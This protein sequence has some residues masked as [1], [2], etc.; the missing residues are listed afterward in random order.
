MMSAPAFSI[1]D[2]LTE[3]AVRF[4]EQFAK[5][6]APVGEVPPRLAEA[7]AYSALAPGKRVR[8]YLVCRSYA[9]CSDGSAE[10]ASATL[11]LQA[12]PLAAAIEC[13]HAFSLVHDDLPAMDDDDLRR[14]RP[15]NH[16]KFG[17][18]LAILAGDALLA[19]AF[20]LIARHAPTPERAARLTLELARGAGWSGMIGGQAADIMGED[21]APDP[22]L[23]AF[24][25]A[26]K[27]A[28]LF[29][30]SCRLGAI[31]A[32]ARHET[33]A[34]LASFGDQLGRAFQIADD[35]LDLTASS[36]Q[37]GKATG[38]DA[39]AGKQTYPRC[40]GVTESGRRAARASAQAIAA[41]DVFG[42]PADD[43]RALARFV[44]ERA[45]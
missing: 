2:R 20:E 27:T 14:G 32:G 25:H 28:R 24:I 22:E 16:V 5:Y 30:A 7:V 6:L 39:G 26:R 44:V 3:F 42:P 23:V 11:E 35:L 29:E 31:A 43:L 41:L 13:V 1:A 15:T 37:M 17:E 12:V 4:D 21:A 8:P 33:E 38:K 18:G 9:L 40:F 10:V 19:L 36:E 34:A 45:R